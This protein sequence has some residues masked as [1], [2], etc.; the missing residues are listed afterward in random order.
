MNLCKFQGEEEVGREQ[1]AIL[2]EQYFAS[3]DPKA[4]GNF[5]FG[6]NSF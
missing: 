6:K 5:I 1:F 2:W 4:P 3:D